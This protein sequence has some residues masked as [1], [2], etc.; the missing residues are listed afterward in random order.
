[1]NHPGYFVAVFGGAV[2]G[3]EAALQLSRRG[4]YTVVFEQNA[5][6]Y[7]KIEDGLP[8]WHVKL[9]N[10]EEEKI[11]EKIKPPRVF[12]VPKVKLGRDI[13]FE[14]VTRN[15]GFSAVLVATGAWKDRPLAIAGIDDYIGRGF[16]YQN[17]FV[18]WFN[19]N[20]E[21]DYDGPQLETYDDAIVVGGGLASLDVVKILMLETTLKALKQHGDKIDMF[22]LEHGGI[23]KILESLG[24]TLSD[25]GIKGCTL[26]YRRRIG[27]MP[28]SPVPANPTA[29]QLEK[30][31]AVRAKILKNFQAK[32]L[33]QFRECHAPVE[34]IVVG[35]RLAGLTFQRTNMVEGKAVPIPDSD[36]EV[37]SPLVISS[38]GSI[39]EGIAGMPARGDIFR[40][41]DPE[42]GAVEGYENVFALGNAV[43]GRGNINDSLHHGRKVS[44]HVMDNHLHWLEEDYEELLRQTSREVEHK[45]SMISAQLTRKNLLPA[46]TIQA[47]RQRIQEWQQRVNYDGNYDRWIASHLPPRLE[48][49]LEDANGQH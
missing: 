3:S 20:H 29:E 9:R 24:V 37:R 21:P 12:F 10:K 45:I 25:L 26:Y 49:M 38:I 32:Y 16:Y 36:E 44:E 48:N 23:A 47:I 42:S 18:A 15:W 17:P 34:K 41:R 4:I 11:D 22:T 6:P 39:P 30:A 28:L 46:E 8:K 13:D 27:D 5:L 33:F 40:I 14:D 31:G 7:G 19:H 43:T 35:D 1:M 2:A